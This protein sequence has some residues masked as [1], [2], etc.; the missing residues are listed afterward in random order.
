MVSEGEQIVVV[1]GS[2][3]IGLALAGRLIGSGAVVTIVGRSAERLAAAK[4]KLGAPSAVHVVSADV[5]KEDDVQRLFSGIGPLD[6]IVATAADV[7]GVYQPLVSLDIAAARR[8]IDSKVVGPLLLAKHGAPRLAPGG[9]M[10]FTSG[11]AAYRPAPRGSVV[12]AANG[13][14]E[15]LAYALALELA[16]I[17]VNVVSPG[18]VNTPIWDV[19]AGPAKTERLEAM[20]KRLPVG[21]VGQPSDI[22][23]AIISLI[24]NPYIT[25][26]VLHTDGG[27][28]LV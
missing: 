15:S 9:S 18:W 14:L 3:G 21:R 2:S 11:I 24:G 19:I 20:A 5:T 10:T 22:A 4:Q 25:G 12:A 23:D 16:P 13:A 7:A 1:G 17:R 8:V 26:T 28:R 27:Q 6:H